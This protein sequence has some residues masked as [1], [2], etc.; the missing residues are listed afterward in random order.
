MVG[1]RGDRD[2]VAFSIENAEKGVVE[3]DSVSVHEALVG[4]AVQLFE[5]ELLAQR[6]HQGRVPL[7]FLVLGVERP[8]LGASEHQILVVF[9]VESFRQQRIH[10][11]FLGHALELLEQ[12]LLELDSPQKH[13]FQVFFARSLL[14]DLVEVVCFELSLGI[15][16]HIE[17]FLF[18]LQIKGISRF[19]SPVD[20]RLV[21]Q[22]VVGHVLARFVGD[23]R[24][25]G[26]PVADPVL[27]KNK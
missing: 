15:S 26:N 5:D 23:S 6:M 11:F 18:L 19:A 10:D 27:V 13:V 2:V 14:V 7:D 25:F 24:A 8:V 16:Q 4:D 22:S 20:P 17:L 12:S 9:E 1:V 21:H 3:R